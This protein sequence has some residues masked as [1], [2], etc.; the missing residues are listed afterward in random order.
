MRF[1]NDPYGLRLPVKLDTATNG[2]YTPLPL[3]REHH[4]AN[5]LA[6]ETATDNAQ[7][8]GMDR[9]SFLVSAA[10]VAST[11]LGM[12]EAYADKGERG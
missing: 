6:H 8:L 9:R 7:R 4:H 11:L 1:Q 3:E 2:E 10:G 5:R 12:N